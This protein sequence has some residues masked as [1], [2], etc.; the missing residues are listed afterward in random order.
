M[1]SLPT[2]I[3]QASADAVA[4]AQQSEHFAVV[5]AAIQTAE[6]V[7]QAQQQ[8]PAPQPP[9]QQSSG[10]AAKWVGIGVGASVFLLTVAVSAVAVAISAVALTACLLVLR[11]MWR[12]YQKGR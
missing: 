4:A 9:A 6:L 12:D 1:E 10:G 7:R 11:S 5:L 3:E 2:N 8:Q